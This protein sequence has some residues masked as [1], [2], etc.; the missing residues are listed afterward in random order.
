MKAVLQ[1]KNNKALYPKEYIEKFLENTPGG[2]RIVLKGNAPNGVE[3][4]AIGYQYSTKA[5]L[6]FGATAN[7]GSMRPGKEYEMKYT[8]DNGN[9]CVRLVKHPD[10]ISTFFGD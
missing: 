9:V 6:F 10:I 7:A 3:L 2:V 8:D 1:V 4:I 5:T